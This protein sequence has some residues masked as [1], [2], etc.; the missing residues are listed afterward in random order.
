VPVK[1]LPATGPE[2]GIDLGLEAFATLANG[3]RIFPPGWYASAGRWPTTA[4][5]GPRRPKT[6]RRR[7]S[8]REKGGHRRREA[9]VLLAKAHPR[10]KRQRQDF[11]HKR[12]LDLARA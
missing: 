1:P 7:V 11:H 3:G 4:Q 2:T 10:V 6:A 5:D 9:A 12:A 8:R